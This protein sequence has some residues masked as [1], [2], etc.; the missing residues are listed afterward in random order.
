MLSERSLHYV[1]HQYLTHYHTER[2]HQ[3]LHNHLITPEGG[4]G[5]ES[6]RVKRRERLSTFAARI[7]IATERY[8]AEFFYS[9]GMQSEGRGGTPQA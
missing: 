2:N 6:G 1:I 9:D 8:T 4:I 3:G 5:N 7:I